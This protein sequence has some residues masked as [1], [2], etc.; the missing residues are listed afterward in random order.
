MAKKSTD[1]QYQRAKGPIIDYWLTIDK[2]DSELSGMPLKYRNN[3]QVSAAL[4][5]SPQMVR[6]TL[7]NIRKDLTTLRDKMGT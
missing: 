6:C 5:V 2:I 3:E 4:G 7:F 1:T